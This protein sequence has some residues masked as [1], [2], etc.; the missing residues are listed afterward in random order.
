M[1]L[2]PGEYK[3]AATAPEGYYINAES[4]ITFT[5]DEVEGVISDYYDSE[6]NLILLPFDKCDI[7]Y[8][9]LKSKEITYGTP[10]GEDG[11]IIDQDNMT[12]NGEHFSNE[13]IGQ[14]LYV[15]CEDADGNIYETKDGAL[16]PA[17]EYTISGKKANSDDPN[18]Y[19]FGEPVKVTV[20]PKVLDEN[21]LEITPVEKT[22][23]GTTAAEFEVEIKKAVPGDDVGLE[24]EYE[25]D[26][27][28]QPVMEN[29]QPKFVYDE[30]SVVISGEFEDADVGENKTITYKITALEGEDAENYALPEG[31]ISG[32]INGGSI[33]PNTIPDQDGDGIPEPDID[34][35]NIFE[36]T[37]DTDDDATNDPDNRYIPDQDGDGQPEVDSDG[38][39]IYEGTLDEDS[40]GQP[41]NTYVTDDKDDDG[42][43][44]DDGDN[45][46]EIIAN[47]SAPTTPT[48]PGGGYIPPYNPAPAPVENEENKSCGGG[49]GCPSR[50]FT[51]LSAAMNDDPDIWYHEAIDYALS[52]K[53]M[54]GM[55]N[56]IFAP[57]RSL[58][59]AMMVQVLYNMEGRPEYSDNKPFDDVDA[60][61]WYAPAVLWA[62]ENSVVEGYGNYKF[63][64]ND[65]V[66]REQMAAI[67]YRYARFK[68]VDVSAQGDLRQ[69]SDGAMTSDWAVEE[70]RW[71]VAAGMMEGKGNGIL[72][73]LGNATR[74]EV[75]QIFMNYCTKILKK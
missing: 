13:H 56:G 25:Y 73:P 67:L 32:T 59:R 49:A 54:E 23:D 36:G 20:L 22:Y 44:E 1:G 10:F 30:I 68:G 3:I 71:A 52:N 66:T 37:R 5:V 31:G 27:N 9:P 21:W 65:D 17:G 2:S 42:K 7:Y 6:R 18:I 61:D 34:G 69:F 58:S 29:G 50:A 26:K 43:Y 41:D 35:D 8:L 75:A 63:G 55:G 12:M 16:I 28:G 57:D 62:A 72:D 40:D 38:D 11:G 51:D 24:F 39:G 53:L 4:D 48:I 47:E 74:A 60:A 19:D 33:K 15:V 14:A 64:P 70:M 46:D 45:G